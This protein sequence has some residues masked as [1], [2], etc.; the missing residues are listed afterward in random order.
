[1]SIKERITQLNTEDNGKLAETFQGKVIKALQV[2]DNDQLTI[3]LETGESFV[4]WGDYDGFLNIACAD[5]D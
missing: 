2:D 5:N 4:I 1:M 3:T